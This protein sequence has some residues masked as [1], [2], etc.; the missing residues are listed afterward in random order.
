MTDPVPSKKLDALIRRVNA[1]IPSSVTPD[2]R[3]QI[4]PCD[5]LTL[6]DAL[7][8]APEPP[9]EQVYQCP[10]CTMPMRIPAPSQP[11]RDG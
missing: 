2:T 4:H 5:W 6:V 3:I 8:P 9:A 11:P 1:L 10:N 7:Q